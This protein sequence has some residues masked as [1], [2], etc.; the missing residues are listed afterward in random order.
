MQLGVE[1]AAAAVGEALR[2]QVHDVLGVFG[3]CLAWVGRCRL[4]KNGLEGRFKEKQ[5]RVEGL[6]F[7]NPKPFMGLSPW[8]GFCSICFGSRR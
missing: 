7:L 1:E 2:R 3:C 8:K 6:G 4:L 5:Y